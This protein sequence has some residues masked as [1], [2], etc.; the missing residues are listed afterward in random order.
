MYYRS[1]TI[2]RR[3]LTL[4]ITRCV[5]VYLVSVAERVISGHVCFTQ[6]ASHQ[7]ARAHRSIRR[8]IETHARIY[9]STVGT[10]PQGEHFSGWAVREG[11]AHGRAQPGSS[12][13]QV[14]ENPLHV[15]TL[16]GLSS[17]YFMCSWHRT[18]PMMGSEV[19]KL[20]HLLLLH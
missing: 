6:L 16:T 18:V 10:P 11:H 7:L 17:Y 13:N 3:P 1:L 9:R 19:Q 5:F 2:S 8:L 15:L 12:V 14:S 20:L 4:L